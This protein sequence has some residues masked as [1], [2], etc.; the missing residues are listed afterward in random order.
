MNS[1]TTRASTLKA[2]G[3]DRSRS[4]IITDLFV[5]RLTGQVTAAAS[6][7]HLD[8]IISAETLL[9]DGDEPADVSGYGPIPASIARKLVLAS[10]AQATRVRRLFRFEDNGRLV[11]MEATTRAFDGLL[12]AFVRIRDQHCRTP[13]CNAPI[14]HTDHVTE[15]AQGGATSEHNAQG[16][17]EACNYTKQAPGWTQRV[18]SNHPLQ[19]HLVE[20]T[21][22]TGHTHHSRD[23]APPGHTRWVQ[24]RPG[25]WTQAG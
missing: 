7:V 12:A 11:A 3:D 9:G 13:W 23:P 5:T 15:A 14:R 6:P 19:P 24:R 22:P 17:C 16:L 8:L 21:T 1:L 10:P 4:Q 20:I 2:G 25:V 18:I